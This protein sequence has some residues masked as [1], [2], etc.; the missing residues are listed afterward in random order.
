MNRTR[1]A[2]S[3]MVLVLVLARMA[4]AQIPDKVDP[5]E[6]AN[7]R[8]VRPGLATSGKPSAEAVGRLKAQ[9]FKT[10]VD[11]RTEAEGTSTEREAVL[12]QGLRYV[13]VPISPATFSLADVEAVAKVLN[14]PAAAPVLLHCAS[15]NRVGAVWAVLLVQQ[16]R[17]AEDAE[18]AGQEVGL[19]GSA[20]I[21]ATRRVMA[22]L[23]P[24]P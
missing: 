13:A 17:S 1:L 14:D 7:Y 23:P 9:G 24:R 4:G 11:L 5:A 22:S 2:S 8:V 21:E 19:T 15:A 12:A 16:G 18:S 3:L 10:V 6:I 20:M